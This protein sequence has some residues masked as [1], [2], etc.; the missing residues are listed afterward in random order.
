MDNKQIKENL[1]QFV[2]LNRKK[3]LGTLIGLL[4]GLLIL[5][6]GFFKTLL[7]CLTTSIGYYL[8]QR[9]SLEE[10]FKDFIIRIIPEKFK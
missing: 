2:Y 10:D 6:V 4:I 5:I 7:L 3:V 9:W 8:G 1:I